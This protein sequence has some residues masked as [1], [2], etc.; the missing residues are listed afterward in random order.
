MLTHSA[1]HTAEHQIYAPYLLLLYQV[2]RKYALMC[3]D[4][5][6]TFYSNRT[7]MPPR[8][9]CQT[10][11]PNVDRQKQT[12]HR[13][14]GTRRGSETS[15]NNFYS[16]SDLNILFLQNMLHDQTSLTKW[17]SVS[18]FCCSKIRNI[19]FCK[20]CRLTHTSDLSCTEQASNVVLNCVHLNMP[21]FAWTWSPSNLAI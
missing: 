3:R 15:I 10:F 20:F 5:K 7:A 19:L 13:E 21:P 11:Q 16:V 8:C 2:K 4:K 1:E 9:N 18:P 14:R 6:C 12:W 17:Q